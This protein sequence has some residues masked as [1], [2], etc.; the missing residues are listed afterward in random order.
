ML[1]QFFLFFF[2]KAGR[3][4][5]DFIVR[6]LKQAYFQTGIGNMLKRLEKLCLMERKQIRVFTS[7]NLLELT[8]Q[9]EIPKNMENDWQSGWTLE[10]VTNKYF[11]C[12]FSLSA[13]NSSMVS[14]TRTQ[15]LT[16]YRCAHIQ[17]MHQKFYHFNF[18]ILLMRL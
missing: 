16:H 11:V 13:L 1:F 5:I 17:R 4:I 18:P 8:P 6:L 9:H 15:E 2:L 12:L 7:K 3:T 10:W 14:F